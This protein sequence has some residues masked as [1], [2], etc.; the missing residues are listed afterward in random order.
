MAYRTT[1]P[2]CGEGSYL[3]GL[4]IMAKIKL[5]IVE[6]EILIAKDLE[7]RMKSMGYEVVAIVPSAQEAMSHLARGVHD[8][9]LLDI[10]IKGNLDGIG[11]AHEIN[12]TYPCPIIFLTSHSDKLT[13]TRARDCRPAAYILKPFNDREL[14]ISIELAVS[15]YEKGKFAESALVPPPQ[16]PEEKLDAAYNMNDSLFLRKRDRFERVDYG[17]ILWAEAQSNYTQIVA[18]GQ[19]YTMAVTLQEIEKHLVAPFF[20]R[21][22]RS[23]VVNIQK[24]DSLAGNSLYIGNQSIPVS[25]SKKE[26]VFNHFRRL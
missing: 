18:E 3:D 10:N 1:D 7:I 26:L 21:T 13:V 25:K 15:N 16:P 2:T 14:D 22:H 5:L 17:Q 24:I 4:G 20:I 12:K 19:T 9:V 6:D 8:L 11:L 23:Y